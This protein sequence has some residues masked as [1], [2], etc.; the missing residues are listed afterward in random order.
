MDAP[1]YVQGLYTVAQRDEIFAKAAKYPDAANG[2]QN[3]V[4][5]IFPD[6]TV[7]WRQIPQGTDG[8]ANANLAVVEQSSTVSKNYETGELLIYNGQ[9]Y[10]ATEQ[11]NRG[12][13]IVTSGANAN[14]LN[15]R[16]DKLLFPLL[17]K[18]V[19]LLTNAYFVGGGSQ[20]GGG[21]FP[22]NQRGYT[23]YTGAG[24]TIDRWSI[25]GGTL[26]LTSGYIQFNST[27]NEFG[28]LSQ[29]VD[30]SLALDV[31]PFCLS[32]LTNYGLL[33]GAADVPDD[34]SEVVVA[35]NER[36]QLVLQAV[37]A[38]KIKAT[39]R[40]FAAH[41]AVL[42]AAKLEVGYN[43]TLARTN[44]FPGSIRTEMLDP[45]P[46]YGEE[47]AKCQ[48]YLVRFPFAGDFT[49]DSGGNLSV[50]FSLPVTLSA[51][52]SNTSFIDFAVYDGGWKTPEINTIRNSINTFGFIAVGTGANALSSSSS[53][54]CQ[55]TA[56]IEV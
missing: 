43:S 39:I 41:S 17:G 29:I 22:I 18:G 35:E 48:R 42:Y 55:G 34:Q 13:S 15:T 47:L 16:V 11:I 7:G 14:V 50:T 28:E 24:G 36:L 56:L 20:Q 37:A 51:N 9:L 5:T 26:S 33:E 25:S 44:V 32:I 1:N 38:N 53:V 45:P 21:Q 6:G 40:V 30:T 27:V 3:Q 49:T 10:Y 8:T 52:P 4:P 46:D 19:Q 2:L 54:Y 23:S 31:G 12:E